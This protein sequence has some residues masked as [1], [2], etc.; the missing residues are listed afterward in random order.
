M[1]TATKTEQQTSILVV[2][3]DD[4]FRETLSDAMALKG[5]PVDGADSCTDA[6]R[7][8]EDQLPSVILLD[9]QLPDTNG[10][11]FC[12]TLKQDDR[13]QNVPIVLLSARYTEPAD[14]AEGM[15][16]GAESYLSKP[17][18]VESLWDEVSYIL[19]R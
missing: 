8:M 12:R 17:I 14:R 15:L 16:A 1:K 2:D 5:V 11:E 10:L 18:S 19:D 13:Y 7:H 9:V 6:A 3:D 4:N